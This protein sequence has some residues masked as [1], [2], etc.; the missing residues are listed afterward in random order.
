[1][2]HLPSH[3]QMEG[4]KKGWLAGR[5]GRGKDGWKMKFSEENFRGFASGKR[6]GRSCWHRS[7]GQ[8]APARQQASA[9]L[10][11]HPK[12]PGRAS[13]EIRRPVGKSGW[14]TRQGWVG[15]KRSGGAKW[16]TPAADGCPVLQR[17]AR[18]KSCPAICWWPR[19]QVGGCGTRRV[20][21]APVCRPCPH[22]LRTP[23]SA[24][25][26]PDVGGGLGA[27]GEAAG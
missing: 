12:S 1:M 22:L 18:K 10:C 3:P 5:M 4:G 20:S 23:C 26:Q 24:L 2:E 21:P 27:G 9:A 13:A 15:F 8:T 16:S 14:L 19:G 7:L 6:G 25:T 11:L 17:G